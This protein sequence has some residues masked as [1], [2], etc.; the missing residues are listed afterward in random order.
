MSQWVYKRPKNQ[1][2]IE[3]VLAIILSLYT[4]LDLTQAALTI[5][6]KKATAL[7]IIKL[8]RLIKPGKVPQIELTF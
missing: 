4:A 2:I 8:Y 5:L 7:Y 3:L 1:S 6:L